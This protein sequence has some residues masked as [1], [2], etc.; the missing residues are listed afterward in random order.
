MR[1]NIVL[2]DDLLAEA[3]EYSNARSKRELV[4]QAL[5]EFVAHQRRRNML[6]LVGKVHIAEEYDHKALREAKG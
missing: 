1:T 5:K 4:H 6:E 2:D 3:F